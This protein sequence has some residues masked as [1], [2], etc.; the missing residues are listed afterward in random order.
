MKKTYEQLQRQIKALEIEAEKLRRVEVAGVIEKI[1]AAIEHYKL[2]AADLGLA[3]TAARSN[4]N[5]ATPFKR[6]RGPN[7]SAPPK[8][9]GVVKYRHES[10][11]TWGGIGKRP[12]WLRDELAA[13]KK[14]EDFLV[15]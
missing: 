3:A 10:G 14:K 11:G 4:A 15:K 1:R 2:T 8:G 7:K 6:K 12:Q 13:G 9:K 5:A